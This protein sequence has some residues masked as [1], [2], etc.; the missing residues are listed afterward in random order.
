MRSLEA[1]NGVA[2]ARARERCYRV[3]DCRGEATLHRHSQG[4]IRDGSAEV[5][6]SLEDGAQRT[7]ELCGQDL[8][9][10]EQGVEHRAALWLELG[11]AASGFLFELYEGH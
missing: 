6:A 10:L 11:I 7:R 4:L 2:Y 3:N 1:L 8:A 5:S 9:V